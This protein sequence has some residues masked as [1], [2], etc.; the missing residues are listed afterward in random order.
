LV[1][2][3]AA[4]REV[5][6]ASGGLLAVGEQTP[7]ALKR[8]PLRAAEAR[9]HWRGKCSGGRLSPGTGEGKPP[10]DGVRRILGVTNRE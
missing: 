7:L 10:V 3:P 8:K 5:F 2:A 9:W 6:Q 1:S 4:L